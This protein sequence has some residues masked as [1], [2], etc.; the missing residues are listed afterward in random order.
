[1]PTPDERATATLQL[2][3]IMRDAALKRIE[4]TR[5]PAGGEQIVI[6][7]ELRGGRLLTHAVTS[8]TGLRLESTGEG[9]DQALY[10]DTPSHT[11]VVRFPVTAPMEALDGFISES[12]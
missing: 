8:P 5:I 6:S 10:L 9:V 11:I 7:A 1:Q 12:F 3:N 2:K 4:L